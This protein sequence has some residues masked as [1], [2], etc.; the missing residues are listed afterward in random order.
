V[1]KTI[2][3]LLAKPL[4]KPFPS[5]HGAGL[6]AALS[7]RFADLRA[8]LRPQLARL[9]PLGARAKGAFEQGVSAIERGRQRLP[10][11]LA[12]G[13]RSASS[14]LL[15][16]LVLA[17][18]TL[19]FGLALVGVVGGL[20]GPRPPAP[21]A[22]ASS[23]VSPGALGSAPAPSAAASPSSAP[24]SPV[25]P[26]SL[27]SLLDRAKLSASSKDY[28][29]A[30][31]SAK[32]ALEQH[33]EAKNDARLASALFQAAQDKATL[34]P[35]FELLEGPM[36]DKGAGIIH[37]LA[38]FSPKGSP[39]Q[40]RAEAFL[41]SARF[42]TVATPS[43]KLAVAMRRARSCKE[44]RKLLPEVKA[45][46]DKQSLPYLTF[47]REHLGAYGCLKQDKLLEETTRVI[48]ARAAALDSTP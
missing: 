36:Q 10:P 2:D 16:M 18:A 1:I 37:D 42:T 14:R 48:N 20:R 47:F 17:F 6:A 19:V 40:K 25:P 29:S 8:F 22:S 3:A 5:S 44:V 27:E 4:R 15:A 9:V 45:K 21:E 24:P 38:V 39:A 23:G 43:L 41:G 31:V 28:A 35:A 12:R 13:L 46:G 33:P 11:P 30:V 26:P 34:G 7:A 32:A